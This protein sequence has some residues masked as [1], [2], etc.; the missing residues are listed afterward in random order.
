MTTIDECSSLLASENVIIL[1]AFFIVLPDR[2]RSISMRS[3][4]LARRLYSLP[5]CR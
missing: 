2:I 3:S 5:L 4:S 1:S